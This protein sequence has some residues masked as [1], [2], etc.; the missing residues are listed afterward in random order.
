MEKDFYKK[1]EISQIG[2][3]TT[4]QE[5]TKQIDNSSISASPHSDKH[6][7]DKHQSDE[8]WAQISNHIRKEIGD[9]AWRNWIKPLHLAGVESEIIQLETTSRLVRDRVGSHYSD[10]LRIIA[11]TLSLSILTL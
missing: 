11:K 1:E 5:D 3:E 4:I 8:H 6:Y 7:P 9:T 10:K 2:R